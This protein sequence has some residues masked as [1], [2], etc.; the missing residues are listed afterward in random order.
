M[1]KKRILLATAAVLA[2]TVAQAETIYVT[3]NSATHWQSKA[4]F[5]QVISGDETNSR[6]E[7]KL[8]EVRAGVTNQDLI[9][10]AKE[11]ED[12]LIASTNV[13]MFDDKGKL[14]ENLRVVVTPFGAPSITVQ[15]KTKTYHCGW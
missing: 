7:P 9:I 8:L 3:P 6:G 4:P 13:L 1:M 12:T 14:V 10:V 15:Y 2:A 5:K 11:P